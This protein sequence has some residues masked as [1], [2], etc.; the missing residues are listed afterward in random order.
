M[1]FLVV[2]VL[3]FSLTS[4]AADKSKD[5][6]PNSTK[7]KSNKARLQTGTSDVF[8]G[9]L[10]LGGDEDCPILIVEN[11]S[12]S[13]AKFGFVDLSL[14]VTVMNAIKADS[15]FVKLSG[16]WGTRET[17]QGKKAPLFII[18]FVTTE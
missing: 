12:E 7:T 15:D 11:S 13:C 3:A 18:D 2:S 17:G 4:F 8:I 14:Q 16:K 9:S 1:R 10:K 5:R 6:A